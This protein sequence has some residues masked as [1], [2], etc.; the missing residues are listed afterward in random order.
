MLDPRLGSPRECQVCHKACHLD[1][2]VVFPLECPLKLGELRCTHRETITSR[3]SLPLCSIRAHS[4]F[5]SIRCIRPVPVLVPYFIGTFVG[6][7]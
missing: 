1:S 5:V 7:M 4:P 3:G 2:P 6:P